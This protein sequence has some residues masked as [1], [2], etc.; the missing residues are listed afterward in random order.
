MIFVIKL[1]TLR[2][3]A[4]LQDVVAISH[5]IFTILTT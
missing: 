4:T 1:N 3:G 5:V 2:G